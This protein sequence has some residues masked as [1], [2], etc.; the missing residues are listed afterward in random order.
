V[1]VSTA[2]PAILEHSAST[3]A[4]SGVR[5][6]RFTVDEYHRMAERGV[7]HEDDPIELLEGHLFIKLDY[8][9][10]YD[11]PLGIP[12]ESIAGAD[13]PPYPQRRFT[14]REY[15][16]LLDSGALHPALRTELVEGWVVEKMTRHARHD[17]TLQFAADALQ[18]RVGGNW[19][20]RL[21]SALTMDDGEPEP[22]LAVVPGPLG[23]FIHGHPR[24][25]EVGLLV[26]ISDSTLAY[27][28]GPK[29]R[30]YARNGVAR[31]WILNIV[32]RQVEEYEGPTGPTD[33]PAYRSQ[34]VYKPGQSV[35]LTLRDEPME[36]IPVD[37]LI[38]AD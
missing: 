9:P 19:R 15:H 5:L 21:Q 33:N 6:H 26:E 3:A 16:K 24:P 20:L 12:P 30:D 14:V 38:P 23:R 13:V 22:D 11:V 31:Y 35:P 18:R 37:E 28:R 34:K 7:F 10:P 36:A 27:D 32:E 25:T 17:S 8:G 1:Q 2:D 29:L 4:P